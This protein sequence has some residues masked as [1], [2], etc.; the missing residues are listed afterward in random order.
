MRQP[1]S[2]SQ[3]VQ[4]LS[5][6]SARYSLETQSSAALTM[7]LTL[8]LHNL[9]GS[10]VQ[11]PRPRLGAPCGPSAMVPKGSSQLL[12]D[13]ENI[14]KYMTMSSNPQFLSSALWGTF[15][16]PDVDCN[17]VSPWCDG[18]IDILEPFISNDIELL[19]HTLALRRPHLAPFWYGTLLFGQTKVTEHLIPFLKTQRAPTPARPIPEVALWT[20]CPQ[21]YMDLPGSGSYLREDSTI[22]R[23]D[24]W[25]L[26]H[27]CWEVE[28]GGFPFRSTPLLMAS[29]RIHAR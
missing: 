8:P 5:R 25:R 28:S 10:T 12:K 1:P 23:A 11:L 20:G 27:E 4:Y 21:S 19:A 14:S 22:S 9:C 15:W 2:S 18:I 6:F 3:A 24:V 13:F 16:E 17:L 29:I 26:R 7:A